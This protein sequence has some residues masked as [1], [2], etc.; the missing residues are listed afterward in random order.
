MSARV[1]LSGK[2]MRSKIP[3]P[4]NA[5]ADIFAARNKQ[6][7]QQNQMLIDRI[8]VLPAKPATEESETD[9]RNPNANG[10]LT[11]KD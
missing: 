2:V 11:A 1:I 8:K 3:P 7:Q 5:P 4:Y 10:Q 9:P 6:R